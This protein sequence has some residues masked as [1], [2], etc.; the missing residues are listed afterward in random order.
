MKE[1]LILAFIFFI[2]SLAGWAALSH[3]SYGDPV[4]LAYVSIMCRQRLRKLFLS[5]SCFLAP[6]CNDIMGYPP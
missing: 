1:W 5:V 6:P 2:G 4:P 3:G